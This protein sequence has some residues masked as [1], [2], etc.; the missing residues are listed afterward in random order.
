MHIHTRTTHENYE[1]KFQ[2]ASI[3]SL[4]RTKVTWLKLPAEIET[5]T[6]LWEIL[7]AVL[8]WN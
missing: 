8:Q 2:F 3:T 4:S 1:Y 7:V 5:E 6:K